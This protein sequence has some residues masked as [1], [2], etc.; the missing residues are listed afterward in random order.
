MW[1]R[2]LMVGSTKS[3]EIVNDV[4][5]K[6]ADRVLFHY[7]SSFYDSAEQQNELVLAINQL[8]ELGV[9]IYLLAPVPEYDF[10][11]PRSI[12]GI[13]AGR[14]SPGRHSIQNYETQLLPFNFIVQALSGKSDVN[15]PSP[16]HSL[17]PE[18]VCR[19][20]VDGKPLY[21][22]AGHLTLTGAEESGR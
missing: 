6:K 22:D 4:L 8:S 5:Q 1:A 13:G 17:C 18:Q 11:V 7:S 20:Q 16:V 2:P 14:S 12:Y 15:V 21:F 10:H 19:L 3:S 9:K